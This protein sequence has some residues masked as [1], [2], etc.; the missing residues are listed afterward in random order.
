MTSECLIRR[1]RHVN[2]ALIT[3]GP[4][5]PLR[6]TSSEEVPDVYQCL[7]RVFLSVPQHAE[8]AAKLWDRGAREQDGEVS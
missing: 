5:L 2:C 3:A 8:S 1:E 4:E 6:L 7:A